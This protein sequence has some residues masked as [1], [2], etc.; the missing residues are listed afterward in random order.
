VGRDE[1]DT[2]G[3]LET[4]AREVHRVTCRGRGNRRRLGFGLIE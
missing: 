4:G 2:V 1:D 3:R